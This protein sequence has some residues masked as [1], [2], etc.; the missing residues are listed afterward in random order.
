MVDQPQVLPKMILPEECLCLYT[1]A[2]A[3]CVTVILDMS[4]IRVLSPA[5]GTYWSAG[6]GMGLDGTTWCTD[7]LLER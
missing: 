3:F 2:D 6:G 4:M 5:I 7:P 1:L